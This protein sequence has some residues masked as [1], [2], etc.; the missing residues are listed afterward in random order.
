[1]SSRC[2][3]RATQR[4]VRGAQTTGRKDR[5]LAKCSGITQSGTACKAMP[6][7]GSTFCVNHH[8]DYEGARRR[9]NSKG[10][11][12]G[13]RGRPRVEL[14][15]IKAQ[16]QGLADSVLDG[17]VNRADAAVA[18]QILNILLR[19]ITTELQVREQQEVLE[20]LEA[21]EGD[22]DRENTGDSQWGA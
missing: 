8:P 11:K 7:T 6:I 15:G 12:T 18:S 17:S 16:L 13:G 1:M 5:P 19:A 9:R 2:A 21:L 20:R 3:F 22:L 14:A 4:K 10:G